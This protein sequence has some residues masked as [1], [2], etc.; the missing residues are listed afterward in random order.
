MRL[1]IL[2]DGHQDLIQGEKLGRISECTS[3]A[4]SNFR[5]QR[6]ND[7]KLRSSRVTHRRDKSRSMVFARTATTR[8]RPSVSWLFLLSASDEDRAKSWSAS[9]GKWRAVFL[10]SPNLGQGRVHDSCVRWDDARNVYSISAERRNCR[11]RIPIVCHRSNSCD[12]HTKF[13]RY[14]CI[15]SRDKSCEVRSH[16][17]LFVLQIYTNFSS[18]HFASKN[19]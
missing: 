3:V 9:V 10:G 11:K 19:F 12:N 13:P 16:L 2:Q 14:I 18:S 17:S 5:F 6:S 8:A 7:R 15:R 4:I 1:Y